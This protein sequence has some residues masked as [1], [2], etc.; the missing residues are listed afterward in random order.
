MIG[1]GPSGEVCAGRLADGGLDVAIVEDH[2]VGGECS[3]YACM[4]SKALLRPGRGAGR[5]R[6]ASRARRR[7]STASSTPSAA[8]TRRDEVIQRPRRL[9]PGSVARGARDRAVP[10]RGPARRRAPGAGRRRGADRR[11]RRWWSPPARSPRCRRSTASPRSTPWTNREAT[12]AKRR[13]GQAAGAGR[14]PGG[15][16]DGAGLRTLGSSVALVEGAEPRAPGKRS[17]SRASRSPPGC[18]ESGVELQ[19]GA[20]A[21][22]RVRRGGGVTVRARGRR[23]RSS[24]DAAPRRD[25]PP[26]ADERHRPRDRRGRGRAAT[27]RSTT[28]CASAGSDWLYAIGDVNGRALLTHMGKYQARICADHVLGKDVGGDRG[29]ARGRRRWSSPTPRS[30]RSGTRWSRRAR[31]GS[32][33]ARWTWIPPARAGAS[34]HRPR[35]AGDDPARRRRGAPASS[36]APPSSAPRSADWLHAATIAVVGE[37]PLDRLWHAIAGLPHA[38]RDLAEADGG[39]RALRVLA[40]SAVSSRWV[41]ACHR[42]RGVRGRC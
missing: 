41:R 37:V 1:G 16:R 42:G 39:V 26:A 20:K 13:A 14:R 22:A 15:R 4:P 29:P 27:S 17:R 7:R 32:T 9:G 10:R 6:G 18:E 8:L 2:L 11:A 33:P 23:A 3:Y 12:T 38:Q 40:G 19:L 31:P 21:D 30:R 35:T 28:S 24:G 36:S 34:F 5:G 25:R